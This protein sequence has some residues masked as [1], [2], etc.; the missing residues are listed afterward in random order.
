MI[1]NEIVPNHIKVFVHACIDSVEQLEVLA[2]LHDQ[3]E[4][5]WSINLLSLEL[6]ST[7]RSVEK[8]LRDLSQRKVLEPID[9]P[10]FKYSPVSEEV[11]TAVSELVAIYRLRPFRIMDLL[12]TKPL[13]TMQSFADAFRFKK[14]DS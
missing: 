1:E 2:L 5:Q 4:K 7:D 12:F 8:R 6:R 9:S 10:T 14:E 11:K 13:N 3:P